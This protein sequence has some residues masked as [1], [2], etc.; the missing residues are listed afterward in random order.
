M[1]DAWEEIK[2]KFFPPRKDQL[3]ILILVGLLLVV[4]ALPS[5]EKSSA[6]VSEESLEIS[7]TYTSKLEQKLKEHLEL[8]E[9]VGQVQVMLTID[10][11]DTEGQ[12]V[13]GVL[14]IAQGGGDSR[15]Q[16]EIMEAAQA[17]F[18]IEAHKIKIMKMEENR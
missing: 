18:G 15:I 6:A 5:G 8:V 9:G 12:Q 14:V 13:K 4:I 7:S 1:K 17:L 3:L 11:T 2:A 16:K 10:N